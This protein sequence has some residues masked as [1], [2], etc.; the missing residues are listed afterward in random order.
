MRHMLPPIIRSDA[1]LDPGRVPA[2]SS[3]AGSNGPGVSEG[4]TA[5]SA[6]PVGVGTDGLGRAEPEALGVGDELDRC[7]CVG[8]VP[9]LGGGIG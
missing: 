6:V 9:S 2:S 7:V 4:S 8:S 3:A 1:N 5:K